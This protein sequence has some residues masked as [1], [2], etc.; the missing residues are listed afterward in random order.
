MFNSFYMQ[1]DPVIAAASSLLFA[2]VLVAI[3][4]S[5][6]IKIVRRRLASM[7]AAA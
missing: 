4:A 3:G 7:Q 1:P 2:V 5:W 6:A